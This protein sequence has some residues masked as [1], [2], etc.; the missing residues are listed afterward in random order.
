[1]KKSSVG[2][3]AVALVGLV[4]MTG[5][6]SMPVE[7]A[8]PMFAEVTETS[9]FEV[10]ESSYILTDATLDEDAQMLRDGRKRGPGNDREDRG[11]GRD[12]R[13][14][15]SAHPHPFGRLMAAL[16]LSAD[17]AVAVR[18]L[19]EAHRTCV[20]AAMEVHRAAMDELL[21]DAKA[22][23][24]SIKAQLEAGEITREEA[25]AA[26]RELNA[27]VREAIKTSGLREQ[28]REMMKACDD[29]FY[30]G[31]NEILTDEQ[32]VILERWLAR[33]TGRGP[34][35]GPGRG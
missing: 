25:R 31:L 33:G 10:L 27:S 32:K 24:A 21:A 5:C 15:D 9:S 14:S 2:L 29:E 12:D 26:L 6:D 19:M 13:K 17:Q 23:R 20:R 4:A 3:M 7:P 28:A 35:R 11:P 18:S 22:Q 8:A 34:D 16:N 1:M 30:A